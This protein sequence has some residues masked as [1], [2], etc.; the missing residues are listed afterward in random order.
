MRNWKNDLAADRKLARTLSLP[1]DLP[2]RPNS[3]APVP[4]LL[5]AQ[6]MDQVTG[7]KV[8]VSFVHPTNPSHTLT[9]AVSAA[10]TPLYLI[11]QM[12]KAGFLTPA[13]QV[14]QYKLRN[15]QTGVQLLDNATL[16]VAGVVDGTQLAVDHTVT[17][18]ATRR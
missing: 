1:A 9:A 11:D 10:A 12:V 4:A 16:Q 13:E 6:R 5:T 7:D 15:S 18:A 2:P 3:P 17:G 8:T 14:G